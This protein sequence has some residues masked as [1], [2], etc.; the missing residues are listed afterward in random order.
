IYIINLG[1]GTIFLATALQARFLLRG[2]SGDKLLFWLIVGLGLHF[3]PRTIMTAERM[4]MS[5]VI[6]FS[7]GSFWLVLQ[8]TISVIGVVTG[9]GLLA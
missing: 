6:D 8:F 1:V 2:T 5:S 9:I 3:F 4:T 7:A